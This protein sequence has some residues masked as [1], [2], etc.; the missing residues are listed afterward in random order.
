MFKALLHMKKYQN[1]M[2]KGRFLEKLSGNRI[3]AALKVKLVHPVWDLSL[4]PG[5]FLTP[6]GLMDEKIAFIQVVMTLT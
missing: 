2:K 1:I 4:L 3:F 5:Y 6:L